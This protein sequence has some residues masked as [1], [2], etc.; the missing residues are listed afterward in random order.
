MNPAVPAEENIGAGAFGDPALP[1]E[2][3]GVGIAAPLGPVL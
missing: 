2:H 1:V 3:H